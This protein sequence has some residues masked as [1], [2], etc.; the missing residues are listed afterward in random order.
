MRADRKT[1]FV[2]DDIREETGEISAQSVRIDISIFHFCFIML[3]FVGF[4]LPH[5]RLLCSLL[6]QLEPKELSLFI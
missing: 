6:V 5:S 4:V 2:H 3:P 1:R